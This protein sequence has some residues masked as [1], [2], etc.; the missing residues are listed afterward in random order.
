MNLRRAIQIYKGDIESALEGN[1]RFSFI[2][3]KDPCR[4]IVGI[5][6]EKLSLEWG[7]LKNNR[8]GHVFKL[9]MDLE[10]S[11]EYMYY[12]LIKAEDTLKKKWDREDSISN[13]LE[14]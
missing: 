13:L 11:L 3:C 10:N 9:P 8:N 14:H 4:C 5:R 7:M 12:P 1:T 2:E 6:F